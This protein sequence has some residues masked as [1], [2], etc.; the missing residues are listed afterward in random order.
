MF[1]TVFHYPVDI[2]LLKVNNRN[3]RTRCEICS[4]LTIKTSERRQWR[5]SIVNFELVIADWVHFGVTANRI[6]SYITSENRH[7]NQ[8]MLPSRDFVM[9]I[10]WV[11]LFRKWLKQV[12]LLTLSGCIPPRMSVRIQRKFGSYNISGFGSICQDKLLGL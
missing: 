11:K 2:Y 5:V 9:Y 12:M 6:F 4:K 7:C 1:L 10:P 3:T 8:V